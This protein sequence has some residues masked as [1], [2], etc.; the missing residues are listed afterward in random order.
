VFFH[1]LPTDGW[2]DSTQQL[3]W[4]T[5]GCYV[6]AFLVVFLLPLKARED[7]VVH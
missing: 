4:V 1:W 2:F 7:G 3:A 5:I 6:V